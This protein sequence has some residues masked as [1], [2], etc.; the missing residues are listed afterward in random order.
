MG[1]VLKRRTSPTW[2]GDAGAALAMPANPL[3]DLGRAARLA[4]EGKSAETHPTARLRRLRSWL[5]RPTSPRLERGPYMQHHP[6]SSRLSPGQSWPSPTSIG[7]EVYF[8]NFTGIPV[9]DPQR[10]NGLFLRCSEVW[11]LR[12]AILVMRWED[13]GCGQPV[14]ITA[15][16]GENQPVHAAR[17][18]QEAGLKAGPGDRGTRGPLTEN[19]WTFTSGGHESYSLRISGFI[20]SGC[21]LGWMHIYL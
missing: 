21:V 10:A 19:P 6:C 4:P 3:R 17:T 18:Q 12:K 16:H 2:L 20:P 9:H 14:G 5:L 1:I 8:I 11:R 13:A 7:Q 15:R